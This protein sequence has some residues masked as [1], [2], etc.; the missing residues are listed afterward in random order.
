MCSGEL[1]CEYTCWRSAGVYDYVERQLVILLNWRGSLVL[2]FRPYEPMSMST[3]LVLSSGAT[4]SH[5]ETF[6]T[7][8]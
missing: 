6:L 5:S 8:R 2:S 4:K 7:L 3:E 1:G